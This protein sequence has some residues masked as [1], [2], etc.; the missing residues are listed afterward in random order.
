[1][2]LETGERLDTG[3]AR[4]E[5]V[6]ADVGRFATENRWVQ[7]AV[8]VVAMVATANLQ[9][10]WTLFVKPIATK[11]AWSEA[12]IQ[13]SFTIFIV[14]QTWLTPFEAWFVDRFGP[15]WVVAIGGILVGLSWVIDAAASSLSLLYLGGITGGIG[16]GIVYSTCMGNALKWF[17]DRRGLASGITAAAY[18][19]GAALT[20]IP[21]SNM[22]GESGYE[23]AFQVFGIAQGLT[24]MLASMVLISPTSGKL[25]V[26]PKSNVRQT[27]RDFKW[28]ETLRTPAFWVLYLMFTMVATGGLM[29]VAQL[30]PIAEN[31]NLAN[32]RVSLLG[33][34]LGAL[35][36]ALSLNN[37][38]NGA[39]RT[40]FGWLSDHIGRENTMC[41]AFGI[42]GLAIIALITFGRDPVLFVLFAAL[43]VFA[44]GEIFSLFP[45]TS[46]D[47][48]WLKYA[49][50]NYSLLYTAKGMAS[51]VVPLG[52]YLKL[53]TG[54]WLPIFVVASL[55]D[56]A[57]AL[58]ALFVLKPLRVK[59]LSRTEEAG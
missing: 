3:G 48:F 54:S 8:G 19:A 7:L 5:A 29:V 13:V 26:P 28:R 33:I 41:L 44:W 58:I 12:P 14:T 2:T 39:S 17:P 40:F 50:T 38:M 46:A 24:I 4:P 30:G 15:K 6:P 35:P 31:F 52:S 56:F 47:L 9:Y 20:V 51:L 36:F 10:G 22:I 21:I 11:F 59:W 57:A 32:V 37:L 25:P 43:T 45:A 55:F 16:A 1:M 27:R 53:Q 18:G 42:D 34:T 23:R 49:T